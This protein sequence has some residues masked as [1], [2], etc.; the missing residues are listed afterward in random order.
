VREECDHRIYN[1]ENL[2]RPIVFPMEKDLPVF[3]IKNNLRILGVSRDDYFT[4]LKEC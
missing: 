1:R 3:I 2:I 4:K